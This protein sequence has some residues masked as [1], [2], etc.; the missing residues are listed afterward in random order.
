V[1]ESI[2]AAAIAIT[3]AIAVLGGAILANAHFGPDPTQSALRAEVARE[4]SVA[5]NLG[6]YQGSALQPATVQ[7]AIPLPD[8]SPIPAT[9][10]LTIQAPVPGQLQIAITATALEGAVTRS[11]TIES[12]LLA[13]APLPGTTITLG[14][15]VPAPTGAP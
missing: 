12:G 11:A 3:V 13:P 9:V 8:G 10:S 5:E 7:T 14:G 4:L 2:V 1:T 6:K 15:L